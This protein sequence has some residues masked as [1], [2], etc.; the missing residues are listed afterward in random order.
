MSDDRGL[1][2]I[3]TAVC[4]QYQCEAKFYI[5][6]AH[7]SGHRH[8]VRYGK[9]YNGRRDLPIE[10][11]SPQFAA[12]IPGDWTEQDVIDLI[13]WP[14]KSSDSL[15]PA[16]K[17]MRGHTLAIPCSDGGRAKTRSERPRGGRL[18]RIACRPARKSADYGL[19]VTGGWQCQR[20]A[21]R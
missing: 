19:V 7:P 15:Y 16:W 18:P 8:L 5:D 2:L 11:G 14:M 1:R 9:G 20:T 10:K 3:A 4:K 12:T 17:S 13:L 6:A 21:S